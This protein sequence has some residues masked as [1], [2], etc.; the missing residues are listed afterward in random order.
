MNNNTNIFFT[1]YD[2]CFEA[3]K[4]NNFSNL[5]KNFE[6]FSNLDFVKENYFLSKENIISEEEKEKIKFKKVEFDQLTVRK[7]HCENCNTEV[8]DCN[9]SCF[10]CNF[11]FITC[12]LSGQSINLNNDNIT[13][14]LKCNKV[15]VKKYLE[16]FLTIFNFCPYCLVQLIN[17]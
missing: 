11:T 15:F 7:I 9:S 8:P 17:E 13:D 2:H 4:S 12:S 16:D 14:C 5:N 3:I 1:R 10:N 6:S